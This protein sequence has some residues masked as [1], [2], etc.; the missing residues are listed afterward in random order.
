MDSPIHMVLKPSLA[1]TLKRGLSLFYRF[2]IRSALILLSLLTI[3][4]AGLWGLRYYQFHE[5]LT[6]AHLAAMDGRTHAAVTHLKYCE[7]IDAEHGDVMLLAA[8]VARMAQTWQRVQEVLEH[9]WTLYGD[10]E[11][12]TLERL[13]L[14]AAQEETDPV[15]DLLKNRMSQGGDTARLCRQA[16]VSGYIREFRYTDAQAMIE[17]WLTE[18][19]GDPLANLLQGRLEEQLFK[20]QEASET[21]SAIVAQIPSHHEARL[22]LVIVLMQQ[23]RADEALIHLQVLREGLPDSSEVAVQ[24]AAALRQVGRTDAAIQALDEALV[25]YPN[26]S[27]A[28]TERGTLALN[29][30]DDAPAAEFLANAIRIEPGAIGTRN[31]YIVALTRLGRT[32][33]TARELTTVKTL[34]IDSDRLTELIQGPLQKQPNDPNPPY[35]IGGIA[36]RAGQPSEAI[37]W[38]QTALKRNPNHG[39]SHTALAVIHHE[40]GNAV[41]ATQHRA[42]AAQ[43]NGRS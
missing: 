20:Y 12:L 19:P 43:A 1:Q 23:R 8:R 31:L 21:Y 7:N 37:R 3:L 5:H 28:L 27:A 38:F 14:K 32:D 34:T 26:S 22:R 15:A 25:K 16:L 40:M 29:A 13:L 17:V 36:L 18:V 2:P 24:W 9:Y 4:F 10:T 41:L 33:E 39:P 42:L 11:P 6:E 35:E 30:G